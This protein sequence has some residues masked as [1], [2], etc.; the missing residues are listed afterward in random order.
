MA[1][2]RLKTHKRRRLVWFGF[3]DFCVFLRPIIGFEVDALWNR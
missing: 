1:A 2:K 3:R